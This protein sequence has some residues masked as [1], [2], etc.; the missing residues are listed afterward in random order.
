[1]PAAAA[2]TAAATA[3]AGVPSAPTA[4]S[5]VAGNAQATVSWTAS[6]D[7][8]GSPITSYTVTSVPGGLTATVAA[9][10][11]SAV[12]TRL[13]NAT[14]YRFYVTAANSAGTSAPSATSETVTPSAPAVPDAPVITNVTARDSAVEVYWTPPDTGTSTLTGYV[15]SVY[16]SGS[17]VTTVD[18]APSA[19][20]AI[21][22]GLTNGT[23]YQFTV[24]AVDAVGDGPASPESVAVQPAPATA[25]TAPADLQAVPLDGQIQVSWS[26]PPDGGSA[27]T[28]YSVSV[29]PAD[30]APVSTNAGTT[31]AKLTGLSNG[32]A[33]TVSV[34][35]TNAVGTSPVA[36][37]NP[38]TPEA[39]IAPDP[40]TN[41]TVISTGPGAVDLEWLPPTDAGTDTIGSYTLTATASGATTVTVTAPA[42]DCTGTPVLCTT[43]MSGLDSSTAYTFAVTATSPA[44]TSTV[45]TANST[46]T[47]NAVVTQTPVTLSSAALASL[48]SASDGMLYFEQ[49]P[50]EVTDLTQGE[51]LQLPPSSQ[52]PQGLLATVNSVTSQAGLVAVSVSGATLA[53]EYSALGASL[54]LPVN[55]GSLQPQAG[56]VLPGVTMSRP[57]ID[58]RPLA[59]GLSPVGVNASFTNHSFVLSVETDLLAGNSPQGEDSAAESGPAMELSGDVTV[60]PY[61]TGS[62]QLP[63]EVLNIGATIDADVSLKGGV[64]LTNSQQIVLGAWEDPDAVPTDF[65]PQGVV[66]T[67]IAELTTSGSVGI[68]FEAEYTQNLGVRCTINLD[69]PGASEDTCT[70]SHQDDSHSLVVSSSLYGTMDVKAGIQ[71]GISW[72]ADDLAGP[73]VT[74][75]PWLEAAVDTSADPWQDIS[76]GASAGADFVAFQVFGLSTP[77]FSDNDIINEKLLD[78]WNSGGP[79]NAMDITPNVVTVPPGTTT[80]FAADRP[81]GQVSSASLTWKVVSGQS[82]GTINSTTGAF[83]ATGD[84]T[85]VIEA[86]YDGYTARAGIVVN[87]QVM[88][89]PQQDSGTE[90]L[91]D[92]AVASWS[93]PTTG[94]DP[95]SYE[96][97]AQALAPVSAGYNA[98]E[99]V[100][101]PYPDTHAYLKNLSPGSYYNLTVTAVG[102]DGAT[103]AGQPQ[104][105]ESLPPIDAPLAGTGDI[106]D[107]ALDPESLNPDDTGTAGSLGGGVVS[108]N[109]QYVFYETEARSNLAPSSVYDPTDEYDEYIVRESLDPLGG[110]TLASVDSDGNPLPVDGNGGEVPNDYQATDAI[111]SQDGTAVAFSAIAANGIGDEVHDF[112]TNTTWTVDGDVIDV[113]NNGTVL[114]TATGSDG[115]DHVYLQ[116]MNGSPQQIDNCVADPAGGSCGYYA[117]M[118]DDGNLVAYNG[119]ENDPDGDDNDTIY[120]YNASTGS[121]TDLYPTNAANGDE[122]DDPILSADGSHITFSYTSSDGSTIG[123]AELPVGTATVTASDLIDA[124]ANPPFDDQSYPAAINTTGSIVV[125]ADPNLPMQDYYGTGETFAVYDNGTRLQVPT[126]FLTS[127]STASVGTNDAYSELVYTLAVPTLGGES[128]YPGVYAWQLP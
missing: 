104:Q 57:M 70:G 123:V 65:G 36:A 30:I 120:L 34:T 59:A 35:A 81:D 82:A 66:Y 122:L 93:P 25:P 39:A 49:P 98:D 90:G 114:Y 29:S 91:V 42:G 116:T 4:V 56:T 60:T 121:N 117:S 95:A 53:D 68:S 69:S 109:G 111:P 124:D 15:I 8:G 106:S 51:L 96:V 67:V 50:A 46:V 78:L 11:T 40:P 118:S 21:V 84:G 88:E 31:V 47:P 75:T 127:A 94:T 26:A 112:A 28:G 79:F 105:V 89:V 41:L 6:A 2:A 32:T 87:D 128:S 125:C 113:A 110:I 55:P 9:T 52:L 45:D 86:D 99:S 58:G 74:L 27:I 71:L 54:D 97:T 85:A 33:Y 72:Q 73:E 13:T 12:V 18:A 64:Q 76:L 80:T 17:E 92:G 77:L 5:A 10:S 115:V 19:S 23:A 37:A 14:G 44:G 24:T 62:L 1:M 101:V 20:S 63:D 48:T 61:L 119:P 107:A 7:D 38:V 43:T 100:V 102:A 108:G 16:T 83:T 22:S 103:V 126:A 3:A